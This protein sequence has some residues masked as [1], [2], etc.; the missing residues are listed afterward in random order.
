MQ[1]VQAVRDAGPSAPDYVQ[2]RQSPE[3]TA[4]RRKHR[5]FVFPMSLAFLVWY[6]A[7]V[8]LAA[9]AHD[10]MSTPLFGA[11]NVA[12]VLGV[13]QF[14]STALVTILYVRFGRDRLD[15]AAE[16]LRRQAGESR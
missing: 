10:F 3:F 1:D 12:M 8:V 16:R 7:Y 15:P 4:L 9:Y 11:I 5:R 14:V 2:I 13:L 6:L